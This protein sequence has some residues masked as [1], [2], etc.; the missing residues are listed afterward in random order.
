MVALVVTMAPEEDLAEHFDG[1]MRTMTSL[2]N[3]LTI[4]HHEVEKV[5]IASDASMTEFPY[6]KSGGRYP[7]STTANSGQGTQ[8]GR[9]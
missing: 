5:D 1:L 2:S 9:R 4:R 6:S 7:S 3:D 8:V